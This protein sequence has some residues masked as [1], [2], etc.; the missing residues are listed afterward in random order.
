MIIIGNVVVEEGVTSE[1]FSCNLNACK[2]AC[3]WEGDYG[4]PLER[5]EIEQLEN[6]NEILTPYLDERSRQ[7]LDSEGGIKFFDEP[8]MFGTNLHSDGACVYLN[9]EDDIALCGIEQAWK[10]G[11]SPLQKPVS[12]HLYPVRVDH[13]YANGFETMSYDV[14]D[15]CSAA[16][17]KGQ[18]ENVR[19]YEFAKDAIVRK[20]GADFYDQLDAAVRETSNEED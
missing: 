14:W 17:E 5:E 1:K 18:A 15:I 8:K 9:I 16:C 4:A 6:L 13:N 19:V 20:F 2:G 11:V 3:C 10:D 12:C 7:L